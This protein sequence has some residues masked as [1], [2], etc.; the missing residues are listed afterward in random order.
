MLPAPLFVYLFVLLGTLVIGSTGSLS[1]G[2]LLAIAMIAIVGFAVIQ[3]WSAMMAGTAATD[4]SAEDEAA[5]D[6]PLAIGTHV[7]AQVLSYLREHHALY[8]WYAHRNAQTGQ[9]LAS[10]L[11]ISGDAVAAPVVIRA[12]GTLWMAV[13]PAT[14][15]LD[16]PALRSVLHVDSIDVVGDDELE[17]IFPGYE[18]GAEPPL[19]RLFHIPTIVE[20][21]LMTSPYI[22][23]CGGRHDESLEMA[24]DEYMRLERPLVAHFGH[25]TLPMPVMH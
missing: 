18:V 16:V 2:E 13:L 24:R 23:F 8:N 20:S 9:E 12:D 4:D 22:S 15:H 21:D 17:R 3:A 5:V 19:G 10:A 14:E 6:E 7:P 11:H 1:G 25:R